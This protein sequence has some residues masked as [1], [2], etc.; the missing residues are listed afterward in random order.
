MHIAIQEHL[1]FKIFGAYI[2]HAITNRILSKL[3]KTL[4]HTG[5]RR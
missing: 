1:R 5:S 2:V 3:E 4:A